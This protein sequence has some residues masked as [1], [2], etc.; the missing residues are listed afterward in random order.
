MIRES[1]GFR[2]AAV[3]G[4]ADEPRVRV[5]VRIHILTHVNCLPHN[6]TRYVAHARL[7]NRSVKPVIDPP[8][9]YTLDR[10]QLIVF[11]FALDLA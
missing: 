3:F 8:L 5:R 9:K 7:V 11:A 10:S 1:A 4:S 6:S 2:P